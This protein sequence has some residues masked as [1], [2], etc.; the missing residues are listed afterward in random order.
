M[1][2]LII[3]TNHKTD[4]VYL[5]TDD[6]RTYVAWSPRTKEEFAAGYFT[7]F[8]HWLRYEGGAGHVAAYLMQRDLSAFD[9]HAPPRQTAAFLDIVHAGHAPEDTDLDNALD[10]LER[11]A[12]CSLVTIAATNAGAAMEWL[13]DRKSRRAMP[14]RMERCGYVVC[15]NPNSERGI[16]D[17]R[18][19]ETDALRAR[20]PQAGGAIEGGGSARPGRNAVGGRGLGADR[21]RKVQI[22]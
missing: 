8:W 12:V 13:F 3:T 9:P 17:D 10:E 11:P 18:R 6:R 5:P 19:P 4:G 1:L 21:C 16:M 15:R 2:G 7:G 20:R 22:F 14:H